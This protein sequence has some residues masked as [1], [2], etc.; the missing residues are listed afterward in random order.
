[1]NKFYFPSAAGSLMNADAFAGWD[2]FGHLLKYYPMILNHHSDFPVNKVFL[3]VEFLPA[4]FLA[5][6]IFFSLKHN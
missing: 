3:P 1:M 2:F 4:L 5:K 6:M